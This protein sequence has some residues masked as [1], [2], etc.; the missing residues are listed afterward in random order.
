[1]LPPSGSGMISS[2]GSAQ[3]YHPASER[4]VSAHTLQGHRYDCITLSSAPTGDSRVH[5]ELVSRLS[6]EVRTTTTTG[7]IQALKT[8]LSTGQYQPDPMAIAARIMFL[9]E[10]G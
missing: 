10:D 5:M 8:Q 2:L 4:E 9:G 7:D 1:M 3:V 6:N